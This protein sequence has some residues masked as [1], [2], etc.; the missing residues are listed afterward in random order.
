MQ[1]EEACQMNEIGRWTSED[2]RTIT[3]VIPALVSFFDRDHICRFANNHHRHWYG[4]T[5]EELIGLHMRDFLGDV[6]Y[7]T[8]T[9]YLARVA[10]G[11][12][13]AFDAKVPHLDGT[14]RDSS[15]RYVPRM[16]R[17]GFE[18]FYILV[19]DTALHQ[20]R[21][22][23][24]FDGTAVAF[25]ELDV[26]IALDL[27]EQRSAR[28]AIEATR[29]VECNEKAAAL[30]GLDRAV[31]VGASIARLWPAASEPVFQQA[32]A[33]LANG[34]PSFEAEASLARVDGT[35]IPTLCTCAFPRTGGVRSTM[36]LAF[37]DLSERI[38]RE[39]G[40]AQLQADLAHAARVAMLGELTASIAHEVNQPLGAVVNNGN[41]ALRW[42]NRA[43]P[44]LGEVQRSLER[45]IEEARRAADIIARTRALA[46]K[47]APERA[48]TSAA[49]IAREA[50]AL[51]ERQLATQNVEL[52]LDLTADTPMIYADRVQIQQVLVN[53]L[54][55]AGQAMTGQSDP[56]VAT[57]E[58]RIVDSDI[59]FEVYDTGPG[60]EPEAIGRLFDAFYSTKATGMGIGLAVS[61][62]I[63]EAHG[64]VI[65]AASRPGG[66]ACFRVSLPLGQ[67]NGNGR[68]MLGDHPQV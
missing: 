31:D 27:Y 14:A 24:I 59:V 46:V 61:R 32:L 38:E 55:N 10:L 49:A 51:V 37:V 34:A 11:E 68:S 42:L 29:L 36:T 15:I 2:L 1:R 65:S 67:P 58:M 64:G 60:L 17:H 20:H 25:W 23:S 54:L 30:F 44:E 26:S 18:G 13:V 35:L 50:A 7:L 40:L 48:A 28:A 16:G 5:P 43:E 33:A 47:G 6:G 62:T 21:F 41:A 12:L 52:R 3:D 19:F 56:A 22:R 4:R 63:V 9:P 8:R 39:R 45:L 66:G 53:L 57:I